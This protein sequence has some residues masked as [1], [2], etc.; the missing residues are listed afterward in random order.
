MLRGQYL[1]RGGRFQALF[2]TL[3]VWSWVAVVVR[4][5]E[6]IC[7]LLLLWIVHTCL[8]QFRMDVLQCVRAEMKEQ[9]REEAMEGSQSFCFEWLEEVMVNGEYPMSGK[10]LRLQGRAI[11][12]VLSIRIRRW[13]RK[14]S[15]E[16]SA[17]L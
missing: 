7:E 4:D 13:S 6:A 10:S 3:D 14:E 17:V 11:P 1:C 8:Q 5:V 2:D 15:L 12:R 16:G 9:S